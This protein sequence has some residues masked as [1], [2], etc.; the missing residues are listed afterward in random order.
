MMPKKILVILGH[1]RVKSF[2]AGLA[3]SYIKG[4]RRAGAQVR[5]LVLANMKF[6]A[7]VAPDLKDLKVEKSIADAQKDILWA[8]HIVFVYPTWWGGPP[9]LF[10]SFIDRT[11][12]PGF[13]YK[14]RP[15]I[16]IMLLRGRSAR[17]ITTYGSSKLANRLVA[18][19][20]GLK[21]LKRSLCWF[22]GIFPV[23]V[24]DFGKTRGD[25]ADKRRERYLAKVERIGERDARR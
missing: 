23:F 11:F 2:S 25:G 15:G 3:S 12:T 9:A 22:C 24:T 18:G 1:P 5:Y 16:P 10:K 7:T 17:L 6:D 4:A 21:M 20:G 19:A 8:E 13:A 14:Y